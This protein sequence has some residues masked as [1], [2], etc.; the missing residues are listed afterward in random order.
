MKCGC[1]PLSS[2]ERK[3]D[4]TL[5]TVIR[6]SSRTKGMAIALSCLLPQSTTA[7][8]EL[9]SVLSVRLLCGNGRTV[10]HF[11]QNPFRF[12]SRI[13]VRERF[14][15]RRIFVEARAKHDSSTSATYVGEKETTRTRDEMIG[16]AIPSSFVAIEE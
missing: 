11:Y 9:I 7:M 1:S 3:T 5:T 16:F 12:L 14:I 8:S 6:G 15:W 2:G 13:F 10:S 4:N